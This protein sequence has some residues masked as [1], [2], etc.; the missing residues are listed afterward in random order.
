MASPVEGRPGLLIRDPYAYSE[1]VLIV[2]PPL[3]RY[4]EFFDG[5]RTKLDLR[6]ALVR[7]TGDLRVGHLIEQLV[8]TLKDSGFLEDEIFQGMKEGKHRA[9]SSATSREALH[10]GSAYPKEADALRTLI[11]SH[12]DGTVAPRPG[13]VAI[14]APHVSPAGGWSSYRA[15]YR[16]LGRVHAE[17]VFVILGTSHYGEPERFGLTAKPFRTPLGEAMV[18]SRLV[19]RLEA[20]GGPAVQREDYCHAIEHSIE[21]QVVFLQ[22]L[23]GL[24]RILPILVGPFVRGSESGLPE[25][26]EGVRRFLE[27]LSDL[28][29]AEGDRLLFVLGVD[30]AH[31][32]RRYGDAFEAEAGRGILEEVA[33]RDQVRIGRMLAGDAE[34]FWDRIRD[35]GDDLKWCGASPI[36]TFLRAI[37]PVQGELLD[38]GQWNID[39][40]SVVSFAAVAFSRATLGRP[41]AR[42][43]PLEP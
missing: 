37:S 35:R 11:A 24:V 29:T 38:Y 5:R 25:K 40:A 30:M 13:L 42:A 26:D 36:Y 22:H 43:T 17:R 16:S 27:A 21:F 8:D 23:F 20:T 15:A 6:E 2:P 34:G 10:A 1:R 31:M 18:E 3:V 33:R 41:A 39:E 9:F 7:S 32:G 14:A 4:L 12:L 28:S 19:Q